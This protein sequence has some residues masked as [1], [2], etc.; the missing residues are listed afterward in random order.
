MKKILILALCL[1]LGGCNESG[2]YIDVEKEIEKTTKIGGFGNYARL[3]SVCHNGYEYTVFIGVKKGGI[4]QVFEYVDGQTRPK[5]CGA[6][7]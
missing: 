4:T 1:V 2:Q 6:E 5:M 7:Q 3:L